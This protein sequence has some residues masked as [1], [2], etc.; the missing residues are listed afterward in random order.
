MA[1]VTAQTIDEAILQALRNRIAELME[2]EAARA[3][4]R[5]ISQLVKEMDALALQVLSYYDMQRLGQNLV[6]T[7]RKPDFP[8]P[9]SNQSKDG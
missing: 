9:A 4:T 7:V 6:I 2:A 1:E 8:E 5:V 3:K